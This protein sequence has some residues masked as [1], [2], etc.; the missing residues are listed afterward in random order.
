MNDRIYKIEPES[1]DLDQYAYLI[2]AMK[3]TGFV[4]VW[5]DPLTFDQVES[6]VDALSPDGCHM[7]DIVVAA[8]DN[9]QLIGYC[10]IAHFSRN[11][12][13]QGIIEHS[14]ERS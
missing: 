6:M 11:E 7:L 1:I 2:G 10:S 4:T 14:I 13:E 3:D 5:A 9:N 8:F 12:M